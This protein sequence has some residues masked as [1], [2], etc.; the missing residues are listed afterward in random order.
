MNQRRRHPLIPGGALVEEARERPRNDDPSLDEGVLRFLSRVGSD[1][2]RI[3]H[4]GKLS[5]H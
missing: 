5:P 2:H 1:F 3:M 4:V